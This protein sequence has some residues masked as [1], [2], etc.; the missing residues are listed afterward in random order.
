MAFRT[1]L[2]VQDSQ[3]PVE[4]ALVDHFPHIKLLRASYR[5]KYNAAHEEW[6]KKLDASNEKAQKERK[7]E[8]DACDEALEEVSCTDVSLCQGGWPS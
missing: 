6:V 7:K 4:T 8:S 1:S 5:D 3:P 2:A